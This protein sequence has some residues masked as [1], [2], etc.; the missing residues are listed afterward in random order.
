MRK[1]CL[2]LLPI[3]VLALASCKMSFDFGFISSQASTSSS[4]E[5][6]T[7][8]VS[9]EE[10]SSGHK[11]DYTEITYAPKCEEQGY[12]LYICDCGY[13]K[14]DDYVDALGHD[15]DEG[16]IKSK[17][18]CQHKSIKRS[19]CS[20]CNKVD[21]V[22]GDFGD[23]CYKK[24]TVNS[25]CTDDGYTADKCEICGV[26]A[27][28]QAS[29]HATGHS[30]GDWVVIKEATL[31]EE[32]QKKKT[33]SKCG[34]EYSESIPLLTKETPDYDS[35]KTIEIDSS[36][37]E[38]FSGTY[39]TGNYERSYIDSTAF[40]GY[41]F[42]KLGNSSG[43]AKLIGADF[44]M[45]CQVPNA[46]LGASFSNE[47]P[48]KGIKKIE[49]SYETDSNARL[50]FSS[51]K[52]LVAY[53]G[54]DSS[55]TSFSFE[56]DEN[57]INFFRIESGESNFTIKTLKIYY[58]DSGTVPMSNYSSCGAGLYR[59]NPKTVSGTPKDGD[60]V[61]CPIE[62]SVSGG[63]YTVKQSKTYTYYSFEY[64]NEHPEVIDDAAW[65]EPMDIANYFTTFKTYPANFALKGSADASNVRTLFGDKYRLVQKFNRTDGYAQAVPYK[66]TPTYYECDIDVDGTYTASNRGVGRLIV[67]STGYD[68]QKG[69]TG[70][71]S[72]PVA[73][74][75]DDHYST[76][77]EYYNN[78]SWSKRYNSYYSSSVG[79][80]NVTNCIYGAPTTL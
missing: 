35:M 42:L 52:N 53:C 75:T 43:F 20:R 47:D 31:T 30:Y 51:T 73:V 17:G 50:Y 68:A 6:T 45:Y 70:Y 57:N 27:N 64:V 36:S 13:E 1:A 16:T 23:H 71:T 62:I 60:K 12:T 2:K 5:I 11:H 56:F 55:D 77:T 19:T 48:I 25:T 61:S 22:E 24:V 67:W 54:I 79:L 15:W 8:E 66:G 34:Y 37:A 76:F 4:G 80:A 59:L 63:S 69:A 26:E 3:S 65:T 74:F 40:R 38:Y 46:T 18:D 7:S 39:K 14:K 33:C 32:G 10:L 28:K 49:M 41:R 44:S 9:K 78:G 29:S 58:T 72:D 21:D